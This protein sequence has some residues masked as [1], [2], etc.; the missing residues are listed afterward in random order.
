MGILNDRNR[1]EFETAKTL[2]A[3]P[4][5]QI[6]LNTIA[7]KGS[8]KWNQLSLKTKFLLMMLYTLFMPL[9]M[10]GYMFTPPNRL[11]K[12][13]ETPLCKL[14]SQASYVLCFLFLLAMSAFQDKYDSF[15][16]LTP[17]TVIIGIW[18]VGIIV[19]EIK[20][21]MFQGIHVEFSAF[22]TDEN[23]EITMVTGQILF[24]V[25]SLASILV[26]LNLLIAMLNNSYKKVDGSPN[27]AFHEPA[28]DLTC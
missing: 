15:L 26:V 12:K 21:A 22:K 4:Y 9:C 5:S 18:V 27:F 14:M 28:P 23:S 7:Y 8:G 17:L 6:M 2:I 20:Q 1:I 3:H 24:A 16:S 10:L 25:Y 19:Q 13:M 11:G